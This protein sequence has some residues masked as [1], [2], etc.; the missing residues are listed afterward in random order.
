MDEQTKQAI[1]ADFLAWSGGDPPDSEH[2][3][4]VYVDYAA[5]AD[6]DSNEV[7]RLLED[8]MQEPDDKT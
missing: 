8:W 3:I 4:T 7:R 2:Q 1:R 6:W 5:H